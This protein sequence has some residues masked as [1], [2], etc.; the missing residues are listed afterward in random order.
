MRGAHDGSVAVVI[1]S[2]WRQPAHDGGV[3][4]AGREPAGAVNGP[5]AH[6][7]ASVATGRGDAHAG[8]GAALQAPLH[9]RHACKTNPQLGTALK[10]HFPT[11]RSAFT[12][13]SNT[14]GRHN[15]TQQLWSVPPAWGRCEAGGKLRAHHG[16]G[17]VVGH[18]GD[19]DDGGVLCERQMALQSTTTMTS[20]LHG[21]VELEEHSSGCQSSMQG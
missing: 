4:R 10:S 20:C 7:R 16:C 8:V 9:L 14:C 21:H 3:Q 5:A 15:L 12:I 19:V 6:V 11:K 2:R 1:F 17:R 18:P 13:R